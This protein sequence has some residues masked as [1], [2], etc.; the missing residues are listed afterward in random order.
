MLLLQYFNLEGSS[1]L[2]HSAEKEHIRRVGGGTQ[3]YVVVRIRLSNVC[4]RKREYKYVKSWG[5]MGV[6]GAKRRSGTRPCACLI[7][8][9]DKERGV[10]G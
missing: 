10:C 2:R 8:K 5:E 1:S 6:G 9:G 7:R 4:Q 3:G